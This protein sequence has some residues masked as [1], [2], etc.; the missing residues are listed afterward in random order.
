MRA[1]DAAAADSKLGEN[2]SSAAEGGDTSQRTSKAP[3]AVI[4]RGPSGALTPHMSGEYPAGSA[5]EGGTAPEPVALLVRVDAAGLGQVIPLAS[6]G[7]RVT[8]YCEASSGE[9]ALEVKLGPAPQGRG[10]VSLELDQGR[11]KL[12]REALDHDRV[13]SD[14]RSAERMLRDGD[15]VSFGGSVRFRF[16]EPRRREAVSR[17]G[18]SVEP[19]SGRFERVLPAGH[20]REV[21]RSEAAFAKR[22]RTGLSLLMVEP[23]STPTERST[24]DVARTPDPI[25]VWLNA[26][27][28]REDLILDAG[29]GRYVLVLRATDLEGAYALAERICRL[30]QAV[31]MPAVAGGVLRLRAGC[32]SLA[33]AHHDAEALVDLAARRLR[34]AQERR[35]QTVVAGQTLCR[36]LARGSGSAEEA[37]TWA[38]VVRHTATTIESVPPEFQAVLALRHQEEQTF[39]EIGAYFEITEDEA[40]DVYEEALAALRAPSN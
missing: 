39:A 27:V 16:V 25:A 34:L 6:V 35:C 38:C 1:F 19:S 31:V 11:W 29:R 15:E 3:H 12:G 26:H 36:C 32:A 5:S 22:H 33:C 14:W 40:R 23:E 13:G 7:E 17:A 8:L 21:V 10:Q 2:P 28:R 30:S 18:E 9:G 24:T 4:V 37:E 20:L